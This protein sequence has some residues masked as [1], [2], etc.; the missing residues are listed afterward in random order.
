MSNKVKIGLG[1]EEVEVGQ[2]R[3]MDKGSLK[4]FFSMCIYPRGQKILDCRYFVQGD[5][6]WFNFPQKEVKFS[7]GRKT[8]YIPYVSFGDKEFLDQLKIA[9]L[10]ILKTMETSSEGKPHQ[11]SKN[12]VQAEPP[13]DWQELP[14]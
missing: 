11:A 4:A 12:T 6:R 10:T 2:F 14:F 9:T 1:P 8:E 13:S 5:K 7:D 3:I